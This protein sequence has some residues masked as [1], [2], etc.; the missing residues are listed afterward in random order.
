M[1]MKAGSKSTFEGNQRWSKW[2]TVFII[3]CFVFDTFGKIGRLFVIVRIRC[4]LSLFSGLSQRN[5]VL[6]DKPEKF[7]SS[8]RPYLVG[9]DTTVVIKT[10]RFK[11]P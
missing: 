7:R 4:G 9:I 5:I 6:C 2:Q 10:F 1:L 8:S 3:P 11:L